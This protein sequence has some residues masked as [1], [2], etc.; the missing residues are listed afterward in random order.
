MYG[1]VSIEADH[2]ALAMKVLEEALAKGAWDS[3]DYTL[4]PS[5]PVE[6]EMLVSD[7]DDGFGSGF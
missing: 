3:V 6:S 5:P 2:P 4:V 1:F 7:Y